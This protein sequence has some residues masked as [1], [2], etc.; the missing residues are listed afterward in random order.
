MF[1]HARVFGFTAAILSGVAIYLVGFTF[2]EFK[3]NHERNLTYAQGYQTGYLKAEV[4]HNMVLRESNK[5]LD[6]FAE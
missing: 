2:G 6:P 4:K 5:D 1:N 3:R